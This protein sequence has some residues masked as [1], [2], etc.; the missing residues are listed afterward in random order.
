MSDRKTDL[1]DKLN[2]LSLEEVA[3]AAEGLDISALELC[4]ITDDIA[5]SAERQGHTEP[6]FLV[7]LGFM[8][9]ISARKMTNGND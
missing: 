5:A 1:L 7:T 8:A 9:G 2:A 4:E 3:S 6:G